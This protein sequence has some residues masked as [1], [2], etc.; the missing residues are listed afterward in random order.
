MQHQWF[1][2][3]LAAHAALHDILGH[4][5]ILLRAFSYRYSEYLMEE[6]LHDKE[7]KMFSLRLTNRN[8]I[9]HAKFIL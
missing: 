6:K 7:R 5:K 2:K 1:H 8:V 4:L 3:T 9:S